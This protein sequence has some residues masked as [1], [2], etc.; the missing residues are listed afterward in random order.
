M[1]PPRFPLLL[2]LTV[3]AALSCRGADAAAPGLKDAYRDAFLVGVA[4]N[5]TQVEEK[6]PRATALID[7]EFN[8]VTAEDAMKWDAT[9]PGEGRF[10]F[11]AADRFV[12]FAER[13]RLAVIGHNLCWHNQL[14]AWVS[15][16]APG[17]KELTREVL[18]ERLHRHIQEVAGHFK[19]RVKG[20]DVVNEAIRDGN[21]E[22]RDS[23]FYRLLGKEFLVLAFKWAREADPHAELYYNDYNLDQDDK[24]RATAIELVKYL[25]SQGA[26]ID[27]IGLQGHYNLTYPSLEKIDETIRLFAELGLKVEI[28]ELD[29]MAVTNAQVSGS[30]DAAS[31][32]AGKHDAAD[33]R[34][35][36]T[37]KKPPH[38]LS[39]ELQQAQAQRYGDLFRI[40]LKYRDAVDRVTVW[41]VRDAD[42]WR[43]YSSPLLFDDAYQP[44]PAYEAVLNAAK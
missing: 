40:F 14:P 16:P 28:T 24:K 43:R 30:L 10:T 1:F 22:Y 3:L 33:R 11:D 12:A 15:K 44:K 34:L 23:I 4:V 8:S 5:A 2:G 6:D 20:W 27:G 32:T 18:M 25:R 41:G 35:I 31:S 17:Q 7:R 42:S 13:H 36:W 39:P 9:E 38:P 19:G 29:V 37:R 26:P 21:G